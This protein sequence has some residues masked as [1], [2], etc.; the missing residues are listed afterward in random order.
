MTV[1]WHDAFR[2][3][4]SIFAIWLDYN[5]EMLTAITTQSIYTPFREVWS[6]ITVYQPNMHTN[7]QNVGLLIL[8]LLWLQVR[9]EKGN[10]SDPN[11]NSIP[12]V[13]ELHLPSYCCNTRDQG[14]TILL[15]IS[16][17]PRMW[18]QLAINT[19]LAKIQPQNCS[20]SVHEDK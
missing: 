4:L 3:L 10:I 13:L 17:A 11:I 16:Q 7:H 15:Y 1:L 6:F 9:E 8:H 18:I 19:A 12:W 14:N 5:K 20:L 2:K